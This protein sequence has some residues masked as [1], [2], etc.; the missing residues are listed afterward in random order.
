MARTAAAVR[1]LTPA[2]L[3]ERLG[4]LSEATLADWRKNDR[5]PAYI[6]GESDGRKATVVYPLAEVEAWE[7]R[8]LV[9]PGTA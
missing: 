1:H 3:A 4:D 5:G 2:E 6:R 7:Q 9:R 8:R